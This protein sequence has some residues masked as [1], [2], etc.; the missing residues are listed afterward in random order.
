MQS[1]GNLLGDLAEEFGD[2]IQG[3]N[4]NAGFDGPPVPSNRQYRA[5]VSR[6]EWRQATT[7][8]KWSY[9]ITFEITEPSEHAGKKF[10]E[11]YSIDAAAGA[12]GREKFARLIGE[13]GIDLKTADTSS[14]DAFAKE[15]EGKQF[16]IA[17][18]IWGDQKDRNGIRYLNKDRGQAL[19]TDIKPLPAELADNI[20]KLKADITV[21]KREEAHG[22]LPAS[23]EPEDGTYDE[24][25]AAEATA[26]QVRLPGQGNRPEGVRLPPGLRG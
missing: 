21:P 23:E 10:S 15:F 24:E 8:G 20:G 12:I 3:K 2:A 17:T 22:E 16:V 13:S 26:E 9:S 14:E 6:A 11:Y 7:S 18:R 19:R 5:V 4:P 1:L 25:K